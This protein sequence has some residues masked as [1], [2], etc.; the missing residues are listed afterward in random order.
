M[1][2]SSRKSSLARVR[3]RALSAGRKLMRRVGTRPPARHA[4][5]GPPDL[6]EQKRRFQFEFLISQGLQAEHRLLD[7]GCGALRGGIPLIE[8]LQTGHYVGVEAR[9]AVLEE[10]RKELAE[11]GLE[12]KQ[13]LLINASD[14]AQIQISVPFD[15]AWAFSVLIHMPDE[16]VRAYLGFVSG[17]LAEGGRFYANV[18]LGNR[19]E[20]EWQGFPVVSRP[21]ESYERWAAS[22]GLIVTDVGLLGALGHRMGH[23]PEMMMLCFAPAPT[24]T[25]PIN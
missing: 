20:G 10:G 19:P 17:V 21:R 8:Y 18:G 23:G 25:S 2:D 5:V 13:P 16:V 11:S 4:L 7:I 1:S 14:P 6:W 24:A 9:A 22:R 12:H 3:W 15:F